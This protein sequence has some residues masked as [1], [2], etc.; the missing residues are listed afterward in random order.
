LTF[1]RHSFSY[2]AISPIS[3]SSKRTNSTIQS[4]AKIVLLHKQSKK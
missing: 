1:H 4:P 3:Q 2:L